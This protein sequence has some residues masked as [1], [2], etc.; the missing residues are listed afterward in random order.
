MADKA[1][2]I[3]ELE[4]RIARVEKILSNGIFDRLD[5]QNETMKD[6]ARVLRG[7]PDLNVVPL[8]DEVQILKEQV[9]VLKDI[10]NRAKWIAVGL[11]LTNVGTIATWLSVLF[12]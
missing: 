4:E 12:G 5:S 3:E 6:L 2:S 1:P 9:T 10:Y 11:G 8:R 7:D